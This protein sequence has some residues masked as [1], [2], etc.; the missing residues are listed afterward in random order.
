M[1]P[2]PTA[3]A[4]LGVLLI[5]GVRPAWILW[6]IPVAW[7]LVSGTTLWAMDAPEFAL[8]PLLA[9]LAFSLA[10]VRRCRSGH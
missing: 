8:V 6:P 1:A 4:T 10:A 7:C 2:D 5:A 9:L 3:L